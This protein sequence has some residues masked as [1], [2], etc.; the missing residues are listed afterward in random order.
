MTKQELIKHFE[1]QIK[2]AYEISEGRDP[3]SQ[4]RHYWKG[5]G[6]AMREALV[7]AK[8]LEEDE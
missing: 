2:D 3:E 5:W 4:A 8:A 6:D 7:Y 1:E